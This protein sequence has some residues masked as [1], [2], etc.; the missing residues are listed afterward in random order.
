[1]TAVVEGILPDSPLRDLSVLL[2]FSVSSGVVGTGSQM[3]DPFKSVSDWLS[4]ATALSDWP[5]FSCRLFFSLRVVT[6]HNIIMGIKMKRELSDEVPFCWTGKIYTEIT[7]LNHS[8]PLYPP[9]AP[10]LS[11]IGKWLGHW[12]IYYC[13][14]CMNING[15]TKHMEGGLQFAWFEVRERYLGSQQVQTN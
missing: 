14:I 5:C 7:S 6:W 2:G 4:L 3:T 8:S 13:S 11:S 1:M 12:K 15:N 9:P 10:P